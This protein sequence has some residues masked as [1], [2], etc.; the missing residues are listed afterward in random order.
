VTSRVN[1]KLSHP[2]VAEPEMTPLVTDRWRHTPDGGK[3]P[4]LMRL[5]QTGLFHPGYS[6]RPSQDEPPS[7]KIGILVACRPID[8]SSSGTRLRAKLAAFL[9][10]AAVRELVGALTHVAPGASWK[11][12]AGHGPRTLEAAL[13]T[14]DNPL[15]GVPVASALFLPPT[16]GEALYGRDG[17]SATLV[18]YAEPRAADGQVSSAS[19]LPSWHRRLSLALA[20]A[21]AFAEFLENDLGLDASGD[22]PAQFGVWLKSYHERTAG[23]AGILAG[24]PVHGLVLC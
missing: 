17:R 20:V 24:E 14:G 16:A 9:G 13:T 3:V 10:S 12:L 22:P 2:A 6:A 19:D 7:V 15:E 8:P 18:L 11:N 4:S 1:G 21:R 23:T 5:T